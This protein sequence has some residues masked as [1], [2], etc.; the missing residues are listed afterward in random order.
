M[1]AS[2]R[3]NWSRWTAIVE[4]FARRRPARRRV[5]PVS[6]GAL[7]RELITACRALA[8]SGNES[9]HALSE[10]LENLFRPFLTPTVLE[11]TDREVLY[12]LLDRCKE[13][14]RVLRGQTSTRSVDFRFTP[15][16]LTT[17]LALVPILI[18]VTW[19]IWMPR[20]HRLQDWSDAVWISLTRSN[21]L[22]WIVVFGSIV[23]LASIALLSRPAKS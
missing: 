18:C 8:A 14:E 15:V 1:D 6:F 2:L 10:H 21:D 13:S 3:T 9:E 16:L 11:K 20:W 17:L 5:D 19:R 7:R 23:V 4:L 22:Q 12:D